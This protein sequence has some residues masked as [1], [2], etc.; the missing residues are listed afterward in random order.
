MV[1]AANNFII[2][3]TVTLTA[4]QKYA[5]PSICR[6]IRYSAKYFSTQLTAFQ[7]SEED[8]KINTAAKIN[9]NNAI[10]ATI[11]EICLDGQQIYRNNQALKD[12]FVFNTVLEIVSGIVLV[13]K[14]ILPIQ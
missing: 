4:A 11:S 7:Q 5:P 3:H 6:Y 9:A 10:Y 14:V 8:I 2:N 1:I 12:Q 13:S